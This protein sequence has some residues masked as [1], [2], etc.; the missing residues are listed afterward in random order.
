MIAHVRGRLIEKFPTHAIVECNGVGYMVHITLTTFS[1]IGDTEECKLYTHL[2][3]REDAH[4]LYGFAEEEERQLFRHLISVSGVGASTARMMLSSLSTSE[5]HQAIVGGDVNLL[6]TIKGIGA[7]SAQRIIVDLKDR[8][9]KEEYLQGI[10]APSGNTSREEALSALIAL[11]FDKTSSGKVLDKVLAV[12][13]EN[14]TV[15]DLLKR[16]LKHL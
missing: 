8:L 6:K 15:E 11:G 13:G 16:A 3:I 9:Q 7:K 1:K 12:D 4:T 2:A 10:S 5:I 14:L